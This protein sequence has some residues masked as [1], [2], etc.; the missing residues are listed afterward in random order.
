MFFSLHLG[1]KKDRLLPVKKEEKVP[2]HQ[3]G[4]SIWFFPHS[5]EQILRGHCELR[6]SAKTAGIPVHSTHHWVGAW[7]E[8][9]TS[10]QMKPHLSA[11]DEIAAV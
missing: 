6:P 11:N 7:E 8:S 2:N 3:T 4:R 10:D 5:Q 1:T 9:I